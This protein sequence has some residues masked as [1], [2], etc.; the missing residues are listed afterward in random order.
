MITRTPRLAEN[1]MRRSEANVSLVGFNDS[2]TYM[3][4]CG[5]STA[6]VRYSPSGSP[7][8]PTITALGSG[9]NVPA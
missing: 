5:T 3:V 4:P 1:S 7:L 9:W 2:A 8:L 6:T